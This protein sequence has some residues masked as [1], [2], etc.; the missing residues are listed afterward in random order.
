MQYEYP[1][2][3]LV[4]LSLTKGLR[5]LNSARVMRP[6]ARA[7]LQAPS[8]GVAIVYHRAQEL[9]APTLVGAGGV[10]ICNVGKRKKDIPDERA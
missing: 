6:S 1:T 2:P 8:S 5:D 7:A 4:Q 10:T 3:R 9:L